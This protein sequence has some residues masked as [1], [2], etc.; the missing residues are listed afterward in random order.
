MRD[1]L[2]FIDGSWV[3]GSDTFDVA[4][5]Y[6]GK[7]VGSVASARPEQAKDAVD[8]AHRSLA[9]RFAPAQRSA[10]LAAA[11]EMLGSR[12]DEFVKLLQSEAGKPV[13]AARTEVA[14][15]VNT[16]RLAAEEARRLPGETV[17]L[18]DMGSGS[19][20]LAF[21]VAQP[22]GVV[23]AITPFNFPLNLVVHKIAPALAAG[24][25][26][27]LKP[28][29]KTPLTA[30]LLVSILTEAGLPAG[31]LNLV[32]GDPVAIV[33]SW[34]EHGD[35][36]VI[37]FTGSSEVGWRI[38][39]ESPQKRH[40]LELGSNTAMLVDTSA[41]LERAVQAAVDG[42]F[43]FAGQA[44]VSVQRVIVL[45]SVHDQFVERLTA[46][47]GDLVVGDPA[48]PAT[49]VGPV[50]SEDAAAR[51]E[52]WI[53]EARDD[54]ATVHCGGTRSGNLMQPTVLSGAP[55]RSS[56]S[57][58]EAFGP[59]VS[60]SRVESF[61]EGLAQVNDSDFGLN[62]AV[63]TNDVRHALAFAH[64]AEAGTAM[65]NVS[66]SFRADHM[67]YGGVKESGV[68]REGVRYAIEEFCDQK[69]VILSI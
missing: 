47:V 17:Q 68:G 42:G 5:P 38:K 45:G 8:A 63:F 19:D 6:D 51:L 46:K 56:V 64:G 65:V 50:I 34:C 58:R 10:V 32:T 2:L 49:A 12:A 9:T 20:P 61:E 53:A 21:T 59:L 48:D 18:D 3:A 29:E 39:A 40:L 67:P 62:T 28:S 13:G 52:A 14:R 36:A 24:C 60:V 16:M 33:R 54:G 4:S 35:V 25:A 1:Q 30:G 26:V 22:A 43:G 57:C 7:M 27:V 23:A 11:A 44:C 15:A 66:P 31:R 41:D 55:A 37:S 69:L